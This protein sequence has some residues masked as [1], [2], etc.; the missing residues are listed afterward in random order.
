MLT[1]IQ[2]LLLQPWLLEVLVQQNLAIQAPLILST[3][4]D[5]TQWQVHLTYCY[6][7]AEILK[8]EILKFEILRVEDLKVEINEIEIV[9]IKILEIEILEIEIEVPEIEI[10]KLRSLKLV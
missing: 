8:I 1:L 5:P 6:Y 4:T 2:P 9:Q 3:D 10:F 7:I